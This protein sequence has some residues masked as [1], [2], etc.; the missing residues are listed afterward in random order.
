LEV[1]RSK[2]SQ[3]DLLKI[4]ESALINQDRKN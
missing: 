1:K 2:N 3:A 4:I